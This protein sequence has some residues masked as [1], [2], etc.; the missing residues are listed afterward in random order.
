MSTC[1]NCH[2]QDLFEM[3]L[4]VSGRRVL[5]GHCRACE[6]RWWVPEGEG[7]RLSLNQVLAR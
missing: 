3:P 7:D 5:F 4:E 2:S 6:R 1:P